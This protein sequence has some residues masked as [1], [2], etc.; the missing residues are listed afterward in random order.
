MSK[1]AHI[2]GKP[3]IIK[4]GSSMV[5]IS[6]RSPQRLNP[7]SIRL[8]RS[9]SAGARL[10]VEEDEDSLGRALDV[11]GR[12]GREGRRGGHAPPSARP[13][14]EASAATSKRMLSLAPHG[15]RVP[16]FAEEAAREAGARGGCEGRFAGSGGESE[17][18]WR[19]GRACAHVATTGTGLRHG[20]SGAERDGLESVGVLAGTRGSCD[21]EVGPWRTV[22]LVY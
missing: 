12:H 1:K 6:R 18:R 15:R 21:R 14:A 8:K 9:R 3:S 7:L 10:A 22:L 19:C 4:S 11:A 5:T 17:V 16:T 20:G 2:V 13:T